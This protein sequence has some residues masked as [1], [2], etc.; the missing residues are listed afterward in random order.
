MSNSD[1]YFFVIFLITA[2]DFI[3]D[4]LNLATRFILTK[5]V[6]LVIK[7]IIISSRLFL[8]VYQTS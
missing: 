1:V 8:I 4:F 7:F 6:N 3:S 2:I 5:C